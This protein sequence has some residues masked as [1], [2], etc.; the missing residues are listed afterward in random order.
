MLLIE[1]IQSDWHQAGRDKGYAGQ[2]K[3]AKDLE[4]ELTEINRE[5]S[6]LLQY[7]ADLPDSKMAEF[8]QVN[9]KI[10]E[11]EEK[12]RNVDSQ[13]YQA[14]DRGDPVPDAP[15][16]D[17]WYQLV[18]K[19]AIQHAAENGYDR[20]GLTTG[21]QQITRYS[22]ELRQNVDEITFMP[23]GTK[24]EI[25]VSAKKNNDKTFSGTVV[26]GKFI[27]GAA[28]GKTVEE[29][30]GKAMAKQ[31]IEKK[32]GVIK[33][34]DLTIGGEGMKQYYDKSYTEFLN[35]YG[36]KWGAKVGET[37]IRTQSDKQAL[38]DLD[39]L[40]QLGQD[41]SK[42]SSS[43]MTGVRYLDITPEMKA[44][45]SKGQPLFAAVP[46]IPAAGLLAPQEQKRR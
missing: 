32:D 12:A 10:K 23:I 22:N 46:A 41:R 9:T 34:D 17:T 11:L 36:K 6:K 39:L 30:L 40:E 13:I 29:V 20:I 3:S 31:I 15:F 42:F 8:K 28:E 4:N 27:D 24:G 43:G 25:L 18:L 16:K 21:K 1:E 7:A 37:K 5:R 38:E 26:N 45:V 14:V 2:V 35:K 19:R 33:G 44:G